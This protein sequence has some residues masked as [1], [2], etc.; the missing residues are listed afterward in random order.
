M[1]T[2]EFRPLQSYVYLELRTRARA[3]AVG[4]LVVVV[5]VPLTFSPTLHLL[6]VPA[7]P[8]SSGTRSERRRFRLVGES[9]RLPS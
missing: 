8:K 1:D 3:V 6:D 7:L 9:L 2:Q 4:S 5:L